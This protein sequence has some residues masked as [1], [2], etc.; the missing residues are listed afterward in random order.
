MKED[1]LIVVSLIVAVVLF[2]GGLFY[3]VN[4]TEMRDHEL[5]LKALEKGC[6]VLG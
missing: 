6:V 4:Q 3:V 2:F 1:N 5:N